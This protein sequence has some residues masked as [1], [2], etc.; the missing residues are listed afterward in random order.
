MEDQKRRQVEYHERDHYCAYAPRIVDNTHP[1]V[2]WINSYRLRKAVELMGDSISGKTMLSGCGGDGDEADFFQRRGANLTVIDISTVAL[3]AARL[4]NP[5]LNCIC[6]D[7][8][9]LT[10][11]DGS[12]DWVIVRDGLHHLARPLKGFYEAERVSREGFIILEGQDSLPVRLLSKIGLA[13]NWD[14]A[15]GYVY[16][17][18][19]REIE[20]VFSSIQ[21][22]SEWKIYT[23][24]LP[25]GS[26]LVGLVPA[27]RRSIYP[28]MR[29]PLIYKLLATKAARVAFKTSFRMMNS[30]AGRWGNSL[31]VVARKKCS[32]GTGSSLLED[33]PVG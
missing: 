28:V 12:F 14:P 30:I 33:G 5:A 32:P 1:Y 31:I 9:T 19:R 18:G 4:R 8:E 7:A 23:A 3:R 26:D 16:R 15:G 22:V 25:F 6:M 11:P 29:H 2:A 24:W 17:F 20:K 21:T 27:F 13:E 10:F